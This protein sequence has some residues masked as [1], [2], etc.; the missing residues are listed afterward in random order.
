MN[1]DMETLHILQLYWWAL[2]SL[3]GALLVFLLFVQGG[4]TLLFGTAKNELQ[5]RLL[6]SLLGHK[7][8]ITF[9]T[10]VTFGGAAFASFPLF[11][12]TSFGGAYWLWLLILLLFVIQ[13]VSYEY[14]NKNCNLFGKGGYDL[15]LF[16]N[17][18]FGT[19]LLGVAVGTLFSGGAYYMD[20]MNITSISNP[21]VSY[22]ANDWRGL[23]AI[24]NPF[25]LLLGITVLFAAR[26]LGLMYIAGIY[27]TINEKEVPQEKMLTEGYRPLAERAYQQLKVTGPAFVVLF[28]IFLAALFL[29]TGY[30]AD[31]QSGFISAVKYKYFLNIFSLVWPVVV[32]LVGVLL[33]LGG[34]AVALFFNNNVKLAKKA[35]YI[36]G[37]GVVLAVWSILVCAAFNNT[38]YFPSTVSLQDSL[39]LSNS[40]SSLFTLTVMSYVSIAV[41]FVLWYIIVVWRKMRGVK[42]Y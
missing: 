2:V 1:T 38:A 27:G 24:V 8:E 26:T 37:A 20:K 21:T 32:L 6:V 12:S 40:S 17:G 39:T 23:E 14:R 36:T 28:V 9:T 5:K 4:Q 13:A 16:L 41:P 15:F 3:L 35:F 29:A 30:Q 25:N 33:V 42:G 22:W 7:W 19:I 31:T 18:A 34:L 10:L 11:Y